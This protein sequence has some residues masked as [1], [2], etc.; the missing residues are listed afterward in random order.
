M[1]KQELLHVHALLA[2]V[3]QFWA[4]TLDAEVDTE[5]YETLQVQPNSIHASKEDHEDAVFALARGLDESVVEPSASE[6]A[7]STTELTAD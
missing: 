4:E 3:E 1:R 6:S 7:E 5:S 2:A